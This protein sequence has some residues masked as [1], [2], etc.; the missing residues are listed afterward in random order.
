MSMPNAPVVAVGAI[1]IDDG[2]RVLLV[3]RGKPPGVGLWTVPG[4]KLLLGES[5]VT[6]CER[7]VREE[8]GLEVEVGQ[9]VTVVER[10]VRDDDGRIAYHFVIH[11]YL[12]HVR[13]GEL[14]ADDD[15]VLDIARQ[16]R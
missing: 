1:A 11:D 12:V 5:L 3:Q 4:G 6:G 13:G 9:L 2:G 7:E 15:A 10:V 16:L 8:T 14:A